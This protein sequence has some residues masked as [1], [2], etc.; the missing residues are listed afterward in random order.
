MKTREKL[1]GRHKNSLI[2]ERLIEKISQ[3][4][5]KPEKYIREQV[6]KKAN[7]YGVQS[8]AAIIIW[9]RSLGLST[10]RVMNSLPPHFQEQVHS[11]IRFSPLRARK[12]EGLNTSDEIDNLRIKSLRDNLSGFKIKDYDIHIEIKDVTQ[13]RFNSGQYADAVESA[14]KLV[15]K[16]VKAIVLRKTGEKLDGAKAMGKAF[17]FD[18][19]PPLV[20]FNNLISDEEKDEQRGIAFLFKGITFIRNRKAHED[21]ILNDPYK[22][23]E[24]LAI[25]SVL[26]RLLDEYEN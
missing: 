15:I 16:R 13:R 26:M 10:T 4:I 21:V 20:K 14:Y 17:D 24:Y 1:K 18:S 5:K 11:G 19:Q 2:N 6:S 7:V 3:K 8:P 12:E 25:A 9:A 23:L 22:A